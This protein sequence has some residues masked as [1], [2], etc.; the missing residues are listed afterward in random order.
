MQ[1]IYI[2]SCCAEC[3]AYKLRMGRMSYCE[4]QEQRIKENSEN[5]VNSAMVGFPEWCPLETIETAGKTNIDYRKEVKQ[6]LR[7]VANDFNPD[8]FL[9][10]SHYLNKV[11]ENVKNKTETD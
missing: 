9:E 6:I 4:K 10:A 2:I 5:P 1:K 3:P 8:N 7:I 11:I